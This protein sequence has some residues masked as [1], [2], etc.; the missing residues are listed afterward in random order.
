[1]AFELDMMEKTPQILFDLNEGDFS[2]TGVLMPEDAFGFF[3]PLVWI[4]K[5]IFP[6][7]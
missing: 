2:F 3:E 4:Y 6:K 1:M 7:S 5:S